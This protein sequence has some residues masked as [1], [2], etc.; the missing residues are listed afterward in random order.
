MERR[1]VEEDSVA[2]LAAGS[3]QGL[4][5][6]CERDGPSKSR[7]QSDRSAIK[8]AWSQFTNTTVQLVCGDQEEVPLFVEWESGHSSRLWN[9]AACM[10]GDAAHATTPW[11]GAGLGLAIEDAAI[12]QAVLSE[13]RSIADVKVGFQIY[14]ELMRPRGRRVIESSRSMAGLL[15]GQKGLNAEFLNKQMTPMW[16]FIYEWDIDAVVADIRGKIRESSTSRMP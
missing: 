3:L 13:C 4:A 6:L 1:R 15:T 16:D 7:K 9:G 10:I 11:Q 14:D 2:I 8:Q 12:I 5:K